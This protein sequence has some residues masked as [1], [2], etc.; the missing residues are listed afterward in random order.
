[1]S[2]QTLGWLGLIAGGLLLLVSA[3]RLVICVRRDR[4]I[5]PDDR[6]GAPS[7]RWSLTG[8]WRVCWPVRIWLGLLT[9]S[10]VILILASA[11]L[12]ATLGERN[13]N[14][15]IT[16]PSEMDTVPQH[17]LVRGTYRNIPDGEQIWVLVSP[18]ADGVYYPQSEVVRLSDHQEWSARAVI[19][20]AQDAGGV[21]NVIAVLASAE[22]SAVL[23]E[24]MTQPDSDTLGPVLASLPAGVRIYEQYT[25]VRQ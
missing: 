5:P 3:V 4:P 7:K 11:A 20:G 14:V 23:K 18:H 13:P 1:M 10:F 17:T 15:Y 12:I 6:P 16:D 9:L 24:H 22:A 8:G 25:V 21:Y 19:G 2:V